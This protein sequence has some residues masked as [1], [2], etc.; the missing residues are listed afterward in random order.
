MKKVRL[1]K[2]GLM[3]SRVGFGG[4]PIQRLGE[5]DAVAVVRRCLDLGVNF[6]D[7]A[8]G[9]TVSEGY[10]GKAIAGRKREELII[11]TKTGARDRETALRHLAQSLDSLGSDYI[12]LWQFHGVSTPEDYERVMSPGGALEAAWEALAAGQV[13]HIGVT[14]HSLDL[15][16]E[17]AP[18]GHFETIQ[19]PFNFVA[20][21]ATERLLPLAQ[22][23]DV[24]FIAMKPLGGG[25]LD[26]A[27]L[28]I[29]YL[30]QF[31][32]LPDPGIEKA[33]EIEEIVALVEGDLALTARERVEMERIRAE[34]GAR[35]CHRC[36]YCQPCPQKISISTVMNTRSFWKRFPADRFASSWIGQAIEQAKTCLECGECESRCPYH[37]PIRE[38]L[39]ENVAFYERV[40]GV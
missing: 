23:H 32:V 9:Y 1:G 29:K 16:L 28:A 37:L 20:C 24:G 38:M 30:L 6:I 2:T 18:S 7:T 25:L 26:N 21:E 13:R 11:A 4:I 34:L 12:D 3:V 15:A 27:R 10:I 35:F 31:D 14:S 33:S 39:K 19:F 17:M 22:A 40:V 5:A 8:N 36:E